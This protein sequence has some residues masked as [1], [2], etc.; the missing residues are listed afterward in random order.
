VVDLER[1]GLQR[2]RRDLVEDLL[3]VEGA[4][5]VAH[6]GVV[7]ADD[8]VAAAEVL[9]EERVEEGFPGPAYRI[10]MG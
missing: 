2:A 5:V 1:L 10:S 3:R 9:P 6:T 8:Q 4:V 7:A